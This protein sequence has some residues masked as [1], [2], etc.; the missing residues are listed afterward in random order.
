MKFKVNL[1]L[2]LMS[3]FVASSLFAQE[4]ASGNDLKISG[5]LWM[6]VYGNLTEDHGNATELQLDKVQLNLDKK[7]NDLFTAAIKIEKAGTAHVNDYYVDQNGERV[8]TGSVGLGLYLKEATIKMT[9][10]N[11]PLTVYGI[12]GIPETPTGQFIEN[13]KGDYMLNIDE[14]EF[15]ERFTGEKKYDAAIGFGIKYEK[16]V[17][18]YFT[19]GHGDGYENLGGKN[20]PDYKYAYN[21]RITVSP[22]ESLK[23]SG[24]FTLDNHKPQD[25]WVDLNEENIIDL[26]ESLSVE[27]F[28]ILESHL[29][30]ESELKAIELCANFFEINMDLKW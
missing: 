25:E 22:L 12:A 3:I 8:Y 29:N 28:K 9:P 19:M 27:L 1:A 11:G 13:L 18:A 30:D 20:A 14:T 7:V 6:G 17:D 24:F 10:I 23:I 15:T 21:G 26:G 4:G 16:L 5:E 2:C